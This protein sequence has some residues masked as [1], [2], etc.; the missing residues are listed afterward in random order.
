MLFSVLRKEKKCLFS[1]CYLCG[2][3]RRQAV[4]NPPPPLVSFRFRVRQ[5]RCHRR[6]TYP[7]SKSIIP[8]STGKKRKEGIFLPCVSVDRCKKKVHYSPQSASQYVFFAS[9]VDYSV[10]A[11]MCFWGKKR[12]IK[13]SLKKITLSLNVYIEN[14][15]KEKKLFARIFF[16]IVVE[17]SVRC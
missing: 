10:G 1:G 5:G 11:F 9:V 12:N 15:P 13:V 6:P 4:Y 7:A 8:P 14:F 2:F 17:I 16:L 3:I